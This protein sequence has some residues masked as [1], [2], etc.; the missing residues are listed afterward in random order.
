MIKR[1]DALIESFLL[2]RLKTKQANLCEEILTHFLKHNLTINKQQYDELCLRMAKESLRVYPI[3]DRSLV[4]AGVRRA[5]YI[6]IVACIA[7]VISIG[8]IYDFSAAKSAL[9]ISPLIM[10]FVSML[11][12]LATIEIVHTQRVKAAYHSV[13]ATY[14]NEINE[15]PEFTSSVK[16][17]QALFNKIPSQKN[18]ETQQ[19][20]SKPTIT[21]PQAMMNTSRILPFDAQEDIDLELGGYSM[22]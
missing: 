6:F 21:T 10:S 19:V 16:S 3:A 14:L 22:N 9:F 15:T 8:S 13:I 5:K 20:K 17:M 12:T 18:K 2:Q 4:R 1:Y 7:I 11:V